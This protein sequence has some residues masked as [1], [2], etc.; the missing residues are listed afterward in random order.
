MGVVTPGTKEMQACIDACQKCAQDCYECF[1]E[2]LNEPDLTGRKNCISMLIECAMMCQMSVATMAMSGKFAKLHCQLCA[3]LCDQCAQECAIFKDTH[4]Q[5]CAKLCRTCA[6]LCR[7][8]A[9]M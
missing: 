1:Q 2:C 4:C 7:N 6:E 8:M 5:E 9:A 3:Q